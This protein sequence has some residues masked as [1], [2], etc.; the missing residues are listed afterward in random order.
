VKL[1]RTQDARAEIDSFR[2]N[3]AQSKWLP[4]VEEII[5]ALGG[6]ISAPAEANIWNTPA[7][8][9]QA[10]A[11]ADMLRGARTPI[12]PANKIYA[13]DFPPN[14]SM[15]AELLRQII[16]HDPDRGIENAKE[17]LQADPSDPSVVANLGTIANSESSLAIPFL[18]SVWGNV[19]ATPNARN[20]AFF[21]FSRR[22]PDKEEVAKAIMELLAKPQTEKLGS[23]A[24]YRMTVADH[25]AVL[26]KI[27]TSSSPEKFALMDKIYRNGSALL[28][29]DLL[30][31]IS[32]LNDPKA[33]PFLLDAAQNDRDA[34]VRRAAIQALGSRKDVD[35]ETLERLMKAA[36]PTPRVVQPL[37]IPQQRGAPFVPALTAPESPQ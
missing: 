33:V 34:S 8:L 2:R 11:L 5:L 28:K 4:D 13:D 12:G 23:E 6:Q 16:Q 1:R 27:T 35:V 10:Q 30:M 25:R 26:E 3:Y 20:N 14:A 36:P 9:R 32:R 18:L 21:W 37:R 24:L 15:K 19:A 17:L 29:T 22:N 31:F 7:E